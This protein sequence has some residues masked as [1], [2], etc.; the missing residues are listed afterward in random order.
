MMTDA[1]K[2]QGRR[3]D[4]SKRNSCVLFSNALKG[5]EDLKAR[6]RRQATELGWMAGGIIMVNRNFDQGVGMWGC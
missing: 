3:Y 4:W 6:K 1:R 2:R 5:G